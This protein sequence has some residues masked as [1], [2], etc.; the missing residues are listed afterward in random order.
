MKNDAYLEGWYAYKDGKSI[1]DNPY[2]KNVD[3]LMI[4]LEMFNNIE[5]KRGYENARKESD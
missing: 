1:D 5:W 4:E 3:F 2:P